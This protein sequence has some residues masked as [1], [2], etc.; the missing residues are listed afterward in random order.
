[1]RYTILL[2]VENVLRSS[3]KC[4]KSRF[5]SVGTRPL[6]TSDSFASAP[7]RV[8]MLIESQESSRS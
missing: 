8:P 3:M 6:K 5:P 2:I 1:M 7:F 4:G